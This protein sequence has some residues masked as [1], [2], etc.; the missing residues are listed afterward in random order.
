MTNRLLQK[1]ANCRDQTRTGSPYPPKKI[2]RAL[3]LVGWNVLLVVAGLILIG[4]VSDVY[5]RLTLTK[6]FTV[7]YVPVQF[8]PNVG[9]L[10]KPNAEVRWTT[11]RDFRT[12]SRANSLG[13]LD[14]EPI[15]PER[16]AASCHI[17]I[18]GDS[19]IEV[20]EVAIADKLSTKLEALAAR[21]PPPWMS[22][23]LRSGPIQGARGSRWSYD[24]YS[25]DI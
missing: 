10:P 12:V 13:F 20:R 8:V 11:G 23:G 15:S 19:F 17:A 14:R 21:E 1:M 4:I 22:H 9:M 7:S 6:P 3:P 25:A 24:Y 5:L 18:I 16:A 2:Y